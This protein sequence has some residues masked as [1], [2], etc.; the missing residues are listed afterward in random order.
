MDAPLQRWLI[1]TIGGGFAFIA[2][3]LLLAV[4]VGRRITG[5]SGPVLRGQG[6]RRERRAAA[7]SPAGVAEIENMRQVLVEAS[8]LVQRRAGEAARADVAA[9]RLAALVE[10]SDDAIVSKTL[11]GIITSW[12]PAAGANVR[13]HRAE[14]VG[15]PSS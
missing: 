14:A 6:L 1:T 4:L 3:A 10:S 7:R 13:V 15:S 11:D 9:R 12:N 2:V 8:V 5:R